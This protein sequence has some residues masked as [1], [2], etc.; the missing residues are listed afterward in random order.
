MLSN[1]DLI[2]FQIFSKLHRTVINYK[3]IRTFEKY[4]GTRHGIL[5]RGFAYH[6][7]R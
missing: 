5:C 7:L 6:I 3:I 4:Y 2:R 1:Y